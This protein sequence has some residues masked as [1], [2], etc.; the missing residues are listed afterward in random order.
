MPT[1]D[2]AMS[3]AVET[4]FTHSKWHFLGARA[5]RCHQERR[6]SRHN[7]E[8]WT[9]PV[10]GAAIRVALGWWSLCLWEGEGHKWKFP[11]LKS[12]FKR[13]W[14][15]NEITKR[16]RKS[17]RSSRNAKYFWVEWTYLGTGSAEHGEGT[18][19]TEKYRNSPKMVKPWGWRE[20][21]NRIILNK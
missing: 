4:I 11:L 3:S 15:G 18:S 21:L 9:N 6:N 17:K 14:R 2:L 19:S 16:R 1:Q 8:Y 5:P 10:P 20:L 7:P 12:C 13:P